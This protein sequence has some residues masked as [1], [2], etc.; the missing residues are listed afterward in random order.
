MDDGPF[1]SSAGYLGPV[2]PTQIAP[3][4]SATTTPTY[5]WNSVANADQY[6]VWVADSGAAPRLD[7]TITSSVAGCASGPPAV[8]TYT[9][10]TTLSS[11]AAY[12]YVRGISAT[13]GPG[14]WSSGLAFS[15]GVG[16]AVGLISPSGT[17]STATPPFVW[18]AVAGATSYS[19]WV[20]SGGTSGLI[21]QTLTPAAVGCAGGTGTCS[22]TSGTSLNSGAG[23]WWVQLNGGNWS[24]PLSFSYQSVGVATLISPS[25]TSGTATPTYTWNS[26]SGAIQ[27][28]VYVADSGASPRVDVTVTPAMAG[29]SGGGVC[30][31]TPAVAVAPGN[32]VW[33]IE[34]NA[35]GQWSNNLQFTYGTDLGPAVLVSPTG[36]ITTTTPTFTWN[37]VAGASDYILWVDDAAGGAPLYQTTFTAAASGCAGGTGTCSVT[38]ATTLAFGAGSWYIQTNVGGLWSTPLSFNVVNTCVGGC[39]DGFPCTRDSCDPV[40]GCQHVDDNTLPCSDGN[41]CTTTDACV[42]GTCEATASDRTSC[43]VASGLSPT[44]TITSYSPTFSW[45]AVPGIT[46][47]RLWIDDDNQGAALYTQTVTCATPTC[48]VTPAFTL[49]NGRDYWYIQTPPLVDGIG[50]GYRSGPWSPV[51]IVELGRSTAPTLVAPSGTL[52]TSTPTFTWNAVSGQNHIYEIYVVSNGS[53]VLDTNVTEASVGCSMGMGVCSYTIGTALATGPGQWW[54]RANPPRYNGDQGGP[55]S[56]SLSFTAP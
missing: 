2:A 33:W 1:A 19:I 27:Y 53:V 44:G 48:S 39:D 13:D 31:Y 37:A 46:D 5:S 29:C 17:I 43:S 3:S 32:V 7:N 56:T 24:A 9:P 49:P 14:A 42:A 18:N 4:G 6:E 8:C 30:S 12:W 41:S 11:G 45:P 38:P 50:T 54:V 51:Q 40:L 10:A 55:W 35:S 22:Y 15:A 20:D 28:R 52:A 23:R 47:Y 25:G 26:V 21:Q 16:A 36:D 34:T